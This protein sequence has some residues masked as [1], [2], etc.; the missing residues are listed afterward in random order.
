TQHPADS[1]A[2][3]LYARLAGFLR[4]RE[5]KN[6]YVFSKLE[7]VFARRA[8]PCFDEPAFKTPWRITLHVRKE[9]IALANSPVASEKEDAGGLKTVT[10]AESRP[11]PTYLVAIAVGPFELVDAGKAGKKGAPVRIVVPGGVGKTPAYAAQ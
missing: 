11:L 6:A 9:H 8:F 4:P 1:K 5:A 2:R 7:A 3:L 10:F